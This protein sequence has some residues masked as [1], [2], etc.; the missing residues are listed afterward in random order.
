MRARAWRGTCAAPGTHHHIYSYR[1]GTL[2]I[3]I[4]LLVH[5]SNVPFFT[6]WARG[7]AAAAGLGGASVCRRA[8]AA[9]SQVVNARL[10]AG[11]VG[12]ITLLEAA[13]QSIPVPNQHSGADYLL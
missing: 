10:S 3:Y 6:G 2:Y 13:L 7:R 8:G 12:I 4:S 5:N 11:L 9:L 1:C